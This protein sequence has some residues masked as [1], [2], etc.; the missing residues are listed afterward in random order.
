M[1]KDLEELFKEGYKN[2]YNEVNYL[3]SFIDKDVEEPNDEFDKLIYKIN[4]IV[5]KPSNSDYIPKLIQL[6]ME[7]NGNIK[8]I[9]RIV[10]VL[11][12]NQ[13]II[14]QEEL[15]GNSFGLTILR[16]L[17]NTKEIDN[18]NKRIILEEYN[19]IYNTSLEISSI[20]QE[21]KL[22]QIPQQRNMIEVK[23]GNL[24]KFNK[25]NKKK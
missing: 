24:F 18:D 7:Y 12:N 15:M 13:D 8:Q 9:A 17:L 25:K 20:I 11:L 1:E 5:S 16:D 10:F 21:E 14:N 3:I 2:D 23:G 6:V 4:L 22:L 19:Y